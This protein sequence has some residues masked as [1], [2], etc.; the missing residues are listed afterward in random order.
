MEHA[1]AEDGDHKED[2][3]NARIKST[4]DGGI[5]PG[6]TGSTDD[7]EKYANHIEFGRLGTDEK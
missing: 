2:Q 4:A 5:E 6:L 7:G 1:G 3:T